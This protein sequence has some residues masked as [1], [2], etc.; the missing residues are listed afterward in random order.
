MLYVVEPENYVKSWLLPYGQMLLLKHI[1]IIPVL[2]FA[3]INGVLTK[4]AATISSYNP[5]PWIKAES[6]I[7]VIVFYFTSVLGTLS[8]PHEVEFTIKSE[9]ASKRVEWLIGIDILTTVNIGL[10]INFYTIFLITM[11]VIFLGMIIIS[12]KKVRPLV[13]VFFGCSFIFTMYFGI[14]MLLTI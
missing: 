14:M 11:S 10:K 3:F 5:R 4:R 8:P 9:G 2:V 13:A 1:S 12:F 6:F 7:L